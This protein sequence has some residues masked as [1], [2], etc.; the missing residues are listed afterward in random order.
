MTRKIIGA[1]F[2]ASPIIAVG[3]MIGPIA[4]VVILAAG[5]LIFGVIMLGFY[6]M[7]TSK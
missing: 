4:L 5:A 6:L 7:E 2:I 3:L 1:L